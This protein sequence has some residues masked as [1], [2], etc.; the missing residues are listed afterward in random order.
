VLRL[1]A[2]VSELN[3][4]TDEEVKGTI[5]IRLVNVPWDQALDVILAAKQ[6]GV[7]KMGNIVR[8]AP[9]DK[10][11]SEDERLLQAAAGQEDLLPLFIRVVPVNY[12]SAGEISARLTPI[13]SKRG[14]VDVDA[15]T[16]VLIIK[17]IERVIDDA[18]ALVRSLDAATPQ[19]LIEAKIVEA[20]T[21]FTRELGVQWGGGYRNAPEFGNSAL[22][23]RFGVA[24]GSAGNSGFE[25]GEPNF[26]V[27]L[28]AAVGSGSGGAL[29]FMF[30]SL[31]NSIVLDLRLSALESSGEGRIISSPRITTLD[32]E[33]AQI[34]QGVAIPYATVSAQGTQTQFI[35]AVLRLEVTPHITPDRSILLDLRIQKNAPDDTFRSSTG[36]P[37]ISK[38]EA[39]SR[40]LVADGETAVVGGIYTVDRGSSSSGVPFLSK[41]PI[42]GWFFKKNSQ[43]DTKTEMLLFVTP[44]IIQK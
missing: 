39:A 38:K 26:A 28:P 9:M 35:N 37:A 43:R 27:D 3:V 2:E 40:M 21:T 25:A 18:V 12:A 4:V 6:L 10:L 22:P 31:N 19:V 11:L 8:V 20:N 32:N 14:K 17:D 30:G 36:S 44:R 33:K 5:S 42:L 1:I 13:L 41:I 34:E 29:G 24:G 15:R 16:N 7:R 23:G